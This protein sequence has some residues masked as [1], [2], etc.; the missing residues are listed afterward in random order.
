VR[1]CAE[2]IADSAR[3]G[4]KPAMMTPNVEF[5]PRSQSSERRLG[6]D[7][8]RRSQENVVPVTRRAS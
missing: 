3:A 5:D 2:Q 7:P 4:D 1:E 6:N 8:E